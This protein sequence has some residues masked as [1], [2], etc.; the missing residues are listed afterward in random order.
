MDTHTITTIAEE[1]NQNTI[2]KIDL[3]LAIDN[4]RSMADKQEILARAVP[5]L[6]EDLVNP[7]CLDKDGAP[8]AEQPAGP[9]DPC[10]TPGTRREFQPVLDIHIGIISSSLGGHGADSCPA[11]D[12]NSCPGSVNTSND[13]K[14]HLV[15]RTDACGGGEAPTYANKGFLAW[16]PKKEL[17]P[18]GESSVDALASTLRE[19]VLGTGQIGCGYESQL[20]SWY[21]FL[22]DPEP[23]A[24]LSVEHGKASPVGIDEALLAQRAEFL[25]PDSLLAIVMLSDENDC[26]IKEY[27]QY[28]LAGQLKNPN[29]TAFHMPAARSEC[30]VDPND[31]CCMSCAQ[32]HGSCPADPTCF[33]VNGNIRVLDDIEDNHNLRCFDQKRRFGVDFLYPIDRYTK[34]LTGD[35][36]PN[37][38]GELVPNPIFSDLNASDDL[39]L[40][41]DKSMVFLAGIVGVPW[42]DVA[43]DKNDLT[44]GLKTA[45]ELREPTSSG[46]SAWD[47]ILG[48]PAANKPPL[49]PFMI[50]TIEQRKGTN[51]ITGDTTSTACSPP[52][53]PIN[54]CEHPKTPSDLQ[55]A[56]TFALPEPV[57]CSDP[58]IALCD[59]K[60]GAPGNPLCDEDPQ[61]PGKFTIQARAKAYPGTRE[62]S[63]LKSVGDQ[64]I[65]ASVCAKQLTNPEAADYGYRPAIG[66]LV[67]K[68]KE[69]L[70]GQCFSR[71]L[72]RDDQ[73]HVPCSIVEAQHVGEANASSCNACNGPGRKPID[74]AK[75]KLIAGVSQD[76][77][78][79]NGPCDCFCEVEQL[80]GTALEGCQNDLSPVPVDTKTGEIVNGFCYIDATT[81][82]KTGAP[83]LVAGCSS[84]ERRMI[85]IVGEEPER[86]GS[87]MFITC[88]IDSEELN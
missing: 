61:N 47:I 43:V 30:A 29:G 72:P 32:D 2:T 56:C 34:G 81:T 75:A 10:P 36:V 3:V 19:M 67:D 31:P 23:Y 11:M 39:Q 73:G 13:D 76:S 62:L 74:P 53:N 27:G 50:E 20:E 69:K 65:V 78:C 44:K 77:G 22:V 84:T 66:A 64:G 63:A 33:D 85:R 4:S 86:T 42:Q 40:Q 12:T 9:L 6:V 51:P 48:D 16:D 83:E 46:A 41:R 59:C 52:S 80:S 38:A 60:S 87:T 70:R 37:R 57:D 58:N 14:G 55:F 7:K 45:A 68:L 15:T 71:T 5:D 24:S 35:K 25:R 18:P 49:D 21:R 82:P 8:S 26:S 54:G 88:T 28:F 79:N 1:L 17:S